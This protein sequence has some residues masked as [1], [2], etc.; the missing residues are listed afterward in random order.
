MSEQLQR[1]VCYHLTI[2]N[3]HQKVK[4]ADRHY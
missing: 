3:G 1:H 2:G 4:F